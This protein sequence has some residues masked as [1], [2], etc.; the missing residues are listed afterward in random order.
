V[1]GINPITVF[2]LLASVTA[3]ELLLGKN[4]LIRV[5]C[6]QITILVAKDEIALAKE[7]M[8]SI[9]AQDQAQYQQL[10][11]KLKSSLSPED[12]NKIMSGY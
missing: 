3:G 9:A 1:L 7:C 6:D 12:F 10:L 11:E 5:A 8:R 4:N 2:K